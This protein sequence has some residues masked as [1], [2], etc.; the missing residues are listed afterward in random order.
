MTWLK[1][2]ALHGA[3]LGFSA[4]ANVL[5]YSAAAVCASR[6]ILTPCVPLV[7]AVCYPC[8]AIRT[9]WRFRRQPEGSVRIVRADGE[10]ACDLAY[11][12]WR[13]LQ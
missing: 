13:R 6:R 10:V 4:H 12:G 1:L 9:H 3:R 11:R 2:E 7:T 5:S 8:K